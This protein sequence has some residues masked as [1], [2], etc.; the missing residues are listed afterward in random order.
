MSIRVRL[1]LSYLAM[2][3][4]PIVLSLIAVAII[5]V[6]FLGD[7]K[8]L[9][10][11]SDTH[12][13]PIK[14]VME[15][16]AAIFADITLLSAQQPES[17]MQRSKAEELDARLHKINMSLIVRK[18]SDLVYISPNL[19]KLRHL[20]LPSY[21]GVQKR[22]TE[23]HGDLLITRQKDFLLP[24]QSKASVFVVTD[25]NML[26]KYIGQYAK[27]LFF[28]LFLILILT[29]GVLTYFVSRSI[30]RP[31]RALKRAAEEI[32]EGNLDFEVK[33]YS[34][35][36]IGE[37]SVA[38]EEMRRKLKHS[39]ELQLQ[40]DE[41]RKELISNIS[42]D[43]KTPVTAIKGYVEGI[44]DGVADSPDKLERYVKTIYTKT[45]DMDRLID[46]LFLFSKLDLGKVPFHFEQVEIGQYL[47]DCT[48][49]LYFD[50]EK[51][52]IRLE[53]AEV[54]SGT[55]YVTA[56][57]EKLK[58]VLLNIIGNAVK[59]R[60][61]ADS[62]IRIKLQKIDGKAVISIEDNGQGISA[63]ALP[64]VF[65]RFFRADPSRN[66]ATGGSGL[67][68]AIA[69]QIVE[70]HGGMIWASSVA[71]VG[72]TIYITL[73]LVG[74]LPGTD[75]PGTAGHPATESFGEGVEE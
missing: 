34:K 3:I 73:P 22:Q 69:K 6:A 10:Q 5:A 20:D 44:M 46:E 63:E 1:V 8:S 32:K 15:Q 21:D 35:D 23:F 45:G 43:L 36:E 48:Q 68:L 57:R 58:R 2:L 29:N 33:P 66:T 30:I 51:K 71:G 9:Y 37:L 47:Q 75:T 60:D 70:E 28:S 49:E 24:D 14:D 40:Y 41:N 67:G 53:Q 62:F 25:S 19:K 26:Q 54:S 31:L 56:D 64:H 72:T 16:E 12:S 7:V 42:H 55:L 13:N 38:F 27:W 17:L 4:V 18:N 74:K 11:L 61:K 52:G 65:D 39:I 50:M 59:Y